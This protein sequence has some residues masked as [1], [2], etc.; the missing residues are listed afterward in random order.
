MKTPKKYLFLLWFV[1]ILVPDIS[2]QFTDSLN[3]PVDY[4][5]ARFGTASIPSESSGVISHGYVYP[6]I[7][8]PFG[9][10]HWTPQTGKSDNIWMY[11]YNNNFIYGFKQT[12]SASPWIGDYGSFVLMPVADKDCFR[13]DDRKSWFSHKSEKAYPYYYSVYLGDHNTTVEMTPSERAA[14]FRFTYSFPENAHLVI[15]ALHG[16]SFVKV[17][18]ENNKVI[19]YITNNKG[20]VPDNFKNYFVIC[21]DHPFSD[22][23][24]WLDNMAQEEKS[25]VNG[26][27]AG[28]TLSFHISSGEVIHAKVASSFISYEQAEQ[29]LKELAND[30]FDRVKEKAKT[31]WNKELN[32]I[33]VS[34]CLLDQ[35]KTF[36]SCLYRM[37]LFPRKF[38][39]IN[40]DGEVIHYSPYNGKIMPGYLFTDMGFWDTF[41]A[42]MPF[43]NLLYP[44]FTI[45]IMEGMLNAYKESGWLPEWSAPGHRNCMIGSHSA[46]VIADAY[47]KGNVQCDI[48]MLYNGI[49]QNSRSE[50][51]IHSLGRRGVQY[52]N[53][54]GY[55]PCDVGIDQ[56]ASMTLEY[57][58]DDFTIYKLAQKLKRP[59]SEINL[60]AKR[61]QNYRNLFD[62]ETGLMRE[63]TK[64][65]PFYQ[66][67][68]P[69]KWGQ[70]FTEANSWQYTWSVMHDVKGLQQLMGGKEP[71]FKKL[72]S[73]FTISPA[74]YDVSHYKR[75]TIH[76]IREMQ[77]LDMGQFAHGNEPSHHIPYL[78]NWGQPWKAQYWVR[79]IMTRLYQPTP[80]GLPGDDDNGQMSAWYVFSS[81]G[82]YP[83]CPGTNEYVLGA[84]LF[85]KA[86]IYLE[87][88]KVITIKAPENN[89]EAPYI[90]SLSLDGKIYTR[91]WINHN[92]LTQGCE[93]HFNMSAQPN[94]KRGTNEIDYPYSFSKQV[95]SK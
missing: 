26:N 72:D 59:N 27:H 21:F 43:L 18:P 33:V 58:Y 65:G 12:H 20:G 2:A 37:L 54:L 16:H 22:E 1:L 82:F 30:D 46:S 57:A 50:G 68:N 28:A 60:F 24:L 48:Q 39:E 80:D 62:K 70:D 69:F 34:E 56:N 25:S 78:Y 13:E 67:F 35:Y 38:Y 88:G 86:S 75:G 93:I 92:R 87:N 9:M 53:S 73:L 40:T 7:A 85:K 55:V 84:P 89:E 95:N 32:R 79:E 91:N 71:F 11:S 77:A 94:I 15:D 31:A 76:L 47:L 52:Y 6:V 45:Q 64:K 41:R 51:P 17:I 36:Y 83:C 5:D 10:N 49:L 4:V 29:N 74:I 44:K 23:V 19:G 81:L 61:S 63:R 8:L 3:S 90:H 42:Q 66:S 14:M